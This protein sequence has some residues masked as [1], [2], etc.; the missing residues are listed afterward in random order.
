M[1]L[2]QYVLITA[3]SILQ[4]YAIIAIFVHFSLEQIGSEK[5]TF[6]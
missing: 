1:L 3:H 4:N 5:Q 6:S 2:Y